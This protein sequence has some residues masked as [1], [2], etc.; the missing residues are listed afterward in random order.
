VYVPLIKEAT[1]SLLKAVTDPAPEKDYPVSEVHNVN[2]L[3]FHNA[4]HS[5]ETNVELHCGCTNWSH[6][7]TPA[8]ATRTIHIRNASMNDVWGNLSSVRTSIFSK[9]SMVTTK[10]SRTSVTANHLDHSNLI[11]ALDLSI[12]Q[13]KSQDG[14]AS[15]NEVLAT[16]FRRPHSAGDNTRSADE[17][18]ESAS[19]T[20]KLSIISLCSRARDEDD[21][22]CALGT[23]IVTDEPAHI[24]S[25]NHPSEPTVSATNDISPIDIEHVDPER[26]QSTT[27]PT[28]R[29]TNFVEHFDDTDSEADYGPTPIHE[30]CTDKPSRSV[31]WIGRMKSEAGKVS[32]QVQAAVKSTRMFTRTLVGFVPA[33]LKARNP[34][35]GV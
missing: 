11:E 18:R 29:Q 21:S 6:I 20:R 5:Q 31:K 22:L 35:Q 24:A 14:F 2:T 10:S 23:W 8:P 33:A 9:R 28:G 1:D 13:H 17:S 12:K 32:G 7:P 26:Q 15:L 25:K 34:F 30:S 4:N 19:V 27:S 16:E 3:F